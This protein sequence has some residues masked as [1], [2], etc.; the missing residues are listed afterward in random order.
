M[1]AEFDVIVVGGGHAGCEASECAASMGANVL[2]ITSNLTT[3]GQM[4]C[5]PAIGG[6]AKGQ[7]V[8]EI[9][10]MGGGT[11]IVTD[12]A[13]IQF[14]MLNMSKGPA[15]WSPRAQC[16]RSLFA[17]TWREELERN[18]HVQFWQDTVVSLLVRDDVVY[19]VK[20][21]LN[22]EILSKTVVIAT[23]TFLNGRI[24]IGDKSWGGGRISE[25]EVGGL[26]GQLVS[27]GFRRGKMKTGTPPRIDGRFVD[28]DK[29]VEQKG[30]EY[31]RCFSFMNKSMLTA[32]NQRS[33]F[34]TY[35][36]SEVHDILKTG[37]DRS[38]LFNKVINGKGPRYCPSIEDKIV[39]FADRDKH[40][41]FIEPDGWDTVE[42][43]INGFSSS[44]PE[45]VQLKAMRKIEGLEGV[46]MMRPAY[47]IEYDYF[48]ATQLHKTLETKIVSNLFFAGQINGTT[49]YEEAAGQGM[50]AGINACLTAREE[51]QLVL[52]RSGSYIG[53]LIDDITTKESDEP[54]RMFT[55]RSEFRLLLRQ[56]N[57]DLRLTEIGYS[58]GL[59]TRERYDKMVQKNDRI[60][61]L[62]RKISMLKV[63]PHDVNV[64]FERLGES[65]V[66]ESQTVAH[67][68][69]RPGIHISSLSYIDSVHDIICGYPDD[70]IEETEINVKYATYLEKEAILVNKFRR[71]EAMIIPQDF[72]Y[73]A[74]KTLSSEGREKLSKIRPTTVGQ[75]SRI[76]G[77]SVAD[78]NIL[79]VYL[80][81]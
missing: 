23:G 17:R 79:V 45:D 52:Q 39:R 21:A 37:F 66:D 11:G 22:I 51:K 58:L 5:N 33:C 38:P 31:P 7:I 36:N 4:S 26:V 25:Q 69:T 27:L 76:S 81:R 15:M 60:C 34:L 40:Q 46:R 55:S 43:Y 56:D 2:L 80:N 78:V 59:A 13:S 61:D 57:A 30:D 12:K 29:M 35:T 68:I 28:Y 50:L 9:D 18:K 10:A 67:L 41:I 77:V 62:T 3:I 1:F 6:I 73:S 70:V 42:C 63:A 32:T 71:L 48:P 16:D 75:A 19:G 49:G 53:V 8:R 74:I 54:Y 65:I 24:F 20:T 47:A 72:D 64:L 14:R 44:L